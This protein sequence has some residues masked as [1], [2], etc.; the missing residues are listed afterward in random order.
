MTAASTGPTA[1]SWYS[2]APD[3]VVVLDIPLA[4][5][6]AA[7]RGGAELVKLVNGL[8][9]VHVHTSIEKDLLQSAYWH[10]YG[11]QP[12]VDEVDVEGTVDVAHVQGHT[13][14]ARAQSAADGHHAGSP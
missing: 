3:D 6:G 12:A 9:Q 1:L 2:A 5:G 4:E 11:S 10:Q 8:V 13:C 14:E 7:A